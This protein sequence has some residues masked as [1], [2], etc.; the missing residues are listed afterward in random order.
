MRGMSGA[1]VGSLGRDA[2]SRVETIAGP[3]RDGLASFF[4][5][6]YFGAVA[7]TMFGRSVSVTVDIC[8]HPVFD[9]MGGRFRQERPA[10]V[11]RDV[12]LRVPAG[13][14][15][16]LDQWIRIKEVS[17]VWSIFDL[18]QRRSNIGVVTGP[19][20]VEVAMIKITSD[21]D[22]G[23]ILTY[24]DL[25]ATI[26]PG[27][28]ID[29]PLG[30]GI[31]AT[32]GQYSDPLVPVSI[33][34]QGTI[35]GLDTSL[36]IAGSNYTATVTNVGLISNGIANRA[37]NFTLAN[38]GTIK[39]TVELSRFSTA[40]IT[41]SGSISGIA[42][43]YPVPGLWFYPTDGAATVNNSGSIDGLDFETRWTGASGHKHP[44]DA[45]LTLKNSGSFGNV[46]VSGGYTTLTLTNTAGSIGS[47]FEHGYALTQATITN[48]SVMG[49]VSVYVDPLETYP[50][51]TSSPQLS[52]SLLN[53]V[54]GVMGN[55]TLSAGLGHADVTNRGTMGGLHVAGIS[56]TLE[57]S[58][59]IS[60]TV[61][62]DVNASLSA[63]GKLGTVV[64]DGTIMISHDKLTVGNVSGSGMVFVAPYATLD[65]TGTWSG[66][67][68]AFEAGSGERLVV[69][70]GVNLESF[71]TGF[72]KGDTIDLLG[73][74]ETSASFAYGE[75]TVTDRLGGS[76]SL[77]FAGGYGLQNFRF[78][79]DGHGGTNIT[80]HS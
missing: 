25:A 48:K 36:Y 40:S 54:Y 43:D 73:V 29:N 68:I 33:Y 2:A 38:R 35:N 23:L 47:V 56:A 4:R 57:N 78:A 26:Y 59:L 19:Q 71:I 31:T 18:D 37:D 64:D 10:I 3:F 58:G 28:T 55:V 60:G 17:R 69:G 45:V 53:T 9:P 49:D 39:N 74:R 14:R 77:N 50:D 70:K 63:R 22:T 79:A 51:F 75:L 32:G 11:C 6:L 67:R 16:D 27:V 41:N 34:N 76:E 15:I 46:S 61:Q 66:P 21:L 20:I 30:Y 65:V 72:G 24:P 1:G 8:G 44:G 12:G 42:G 13:R 52:G 5:R 80:W 62:V 7:S